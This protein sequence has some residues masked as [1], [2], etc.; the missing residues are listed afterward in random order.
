MTRP[1]FSTITTWTIRILLIVVMAIAALALML[2]MLGG[3]TESHR[4]GL[5]Q[6]FSD[7]I[8]A[9][10]KIG[11]IDQFN[12]LPQ[13]SMKASNI[14]GMFRDTKNQFKMDK[15]ELAFSFSDLV[16]GHHKIENFQIENFRFAS[17]ST[18]D[19]SIDHAG[20][21][22]KKAN[23]SSQGI[24]DKK[25]YDFSIPL[26]VDPGGRPAY[27][28]EP[29]NK[30]DG[31]LGSLTVKGKLIPSHGAKAEVAQDIEISS[32]H[33]L[34]ATG[35][36]AHDKDGKYKIELECKSGLS[37]ENKADFKDLAAIPVMSVAE[38]CLK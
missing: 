25:S 22:P 2:S 27:Y 28:F 7:S 19:L 38:S 10:V 23:F 24:F 32:A 17:G 34:I 15:F 36:G 8:N 14:E 26:A 21:D 16:L 11:R 3:T 18:Y 5:E 12:I 29:E 20:I 37:D 1:I 4:K 31:H 30:F 6:A 33:K 35:H 9:D 13:L